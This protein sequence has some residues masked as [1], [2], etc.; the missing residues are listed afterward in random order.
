MKKTAIILALVAVAVAP[1]ALRAQEAQEKS[2]AANANPPDH[3]YKLNLTVAD[4]DEAGKISNTRSF[5]TI[6]RTGPGY[7]QSVRTGDRVPVATG[8]GSGSATT[9]QYT[10]IDVGV[11]MDITQVK[12]SGNQL[13]F[14]L[15]A[16]VSS[17][18]KSGTAIGGVQEPIIRQK[19]W[20]SSVVVPIGKP[21]IVFSA[22]DL[23]DKGK[24]QVE[25]T[26]THID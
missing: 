6:L 16:N 7:T 11:N 13:S 10:Y 4:I 20:D 21:T 18:A 14:R 22:D 9:T 15:T 17:F 12:D 3:F 1:M 24:M 8:V 19:K 23:E 25:L 5:A 2:A 26:A